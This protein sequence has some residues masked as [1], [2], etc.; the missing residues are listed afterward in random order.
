MKVLFDH[1]AFQA[2]RIG[3]VS[4]S[5]CEIIRHLPEHVKWELSISQSDN[6]YIKDLIPGVAPVKY[7]YGKIYSHNNFKWKGELYTLADK[8]HIIRMSESLNKEASIKA[9]KKGDFDVFHPTYF[10]PY[11]LEKLGD[12][13]FVLTIHDLIPEK[14]P[15]HFSRSDIQIRGRKA[16]IERA[17][18]IVAV[19]EN[20]KRDIIE[21]YGI[22][23]E[24][25]SVI[26][27]GGPEP[28]MTEPATPSH[29]PYFLFVGARGK[30]KNFSALLKGFG[31]FR[32]KNA[33]V[34]LICTGHPF[35]ADESAEI[36]RLRL[37]G[38]IRCLSASEEEMVKLYN[39][40]IALV[41][42]SRYE[43][44]G[45]PVLEAFAYH[46]PVLLGPGSSLPEVGGDVATYFDPSFDDVAEKLEHHASMARAERDQLINAGL[47]RLKEFSWGKSAEKY[48]E[49]Y[50][51]IARLNT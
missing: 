26:Y 51:S 19:S 48:V 33:E 13:P 23:A 16:L 43:G 7:S 25:I 11:F 24:K 12:K 38:R 9:L 1:Q 47:N 17:D 15:E 27:H 20:T 3:G 5:F 39:G 35:S 22:P 28:R 30:Y 18:A 46:C 2:Q 50:S 8:L 36:A 34:D 37:E 45:M 29:R 42:P 41:Y 10:N 4:K 44:F 14:F 21:I 32:E 49:V 40:A 6:V 31:E